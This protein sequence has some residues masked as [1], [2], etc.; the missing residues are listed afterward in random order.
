MFSVYSKN[1]FFVSTF[2]NETDHEQINIRHS[3]IMNSKVPSC[4]ITFIFFRHLNF[5]TDAT[6]KYI[7]YI[8]WPPRQPDV[9]VWISAN[10]LILF[11]TR[12]F[13]FIVFDFWSDKVRGSAK[14]KKKKEEVFFILPSQHLALLCVSAAPPSFHTRLWARCRNTES[15]PQPG[16]QS[17]P[18]SHPAEDKEALKVSQRLSQIPNAGQ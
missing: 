11:W 18:P 8:N 5:F 16:R 3:L 12:K 1:N 4:F 6:F 17:C 7:I 14:R 2:H 10:R 15:T 13:I 9:G